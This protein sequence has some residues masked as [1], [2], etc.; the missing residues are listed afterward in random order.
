MVILVKIATVLQNMWELFYL[1]LHSFI[2][3]VK[4]RVQIL[5]SPNTPMIK[6]QILFD[7]IYIKDA[8]LPPG[9]NLIAHN[10]VS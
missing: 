1:F 2:L 10:F 3:F 7:Y 9:D 4:S 5:N 6:N 8:Q